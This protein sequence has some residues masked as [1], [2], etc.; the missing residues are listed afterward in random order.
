MA[1]PERFAMFLHLSIAARGRAISRVAESWK[2]RHENVELGEDTFR[3]QKTR[4]RPLC[5]RRYHTVFVYHNGAESY[6]AGR[7]FR[8]SLRV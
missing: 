3:N 7:A 5:D 4:R 6:Y 2:F 8:G 1:R